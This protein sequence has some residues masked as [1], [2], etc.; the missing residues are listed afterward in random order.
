MESEVVGTAAIP[1]GVRRQDG[2]IYSAHEVPRGD[3][4]GCDCPSCGCPLRA[5]QGEVKEPYFS[6]R[7]GY[8]HCRTALSAALYAAAVQTVAERKRLRLPPTVLAGRETPGTLMTFDEVKTQ[9]RSEDGTTLLCCRTG[10]EHYAVVLGREIDVNRQMHRT[11][12][13]EGIDAVAI[14]LSGLGKEA[15]WEEVER[16]LLDGKGAKWI[17]RRLEP[18][19]TPQTTP[20]R[21]EAKEAPLSGTDTDETVARAI[22]SFRQF[23]PPE[24]DRS[25]TIPDRLI[26]AVRAIGADSLDGLPLF[27]QRPHPADILYDCDGRVWKALLFSEFLLC[28]DPFPFTPLEADERLIEKGIP[29]RDFIET[30]IENRWTFRVKAWLANEI[31]KIHPWYILGEYLDALVERGLLKKTG[32]KREWRQADDPYIADPDGLKSYGFLIDPSACAE[33]DVF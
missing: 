27:M 30:L 20:P 15:D 24:P 11:F 2:R 8:E 18:K 31:R 4:C 9:T 1:F 7:P 26:P 13:E 12:R 10:E 33:A 19:T 23:R 32:P 16:Y 14:E 28:K 29:H 5:N 25:V 6:H 21:I 3:A 17:Y 22:K